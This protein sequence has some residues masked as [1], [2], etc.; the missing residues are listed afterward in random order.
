MKI[1]ICVGKYLMRN[2]SL[3]SKNP[4]PKISMGFLIRV[5]E[6]LDIIF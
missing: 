2:W 5:S 6:E 4:I 3:L 1:L